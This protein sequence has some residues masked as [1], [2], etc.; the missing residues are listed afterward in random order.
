MQRSRVTKPNTHTKAAG[1]HETYPVHTCGV[2][3]IVVHVLASLRLRGLR[4]FLAVGAHAAHVDFGHLQG[5]HAPLI[6]G[7]SDMNTKAAR[8]GSYTASIPPQHKRTALSSSS[9]GCCA[10]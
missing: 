5:Q 10:Q 1:A 9:C 2:D 3:D 4:D 8:G 6:D 7:R